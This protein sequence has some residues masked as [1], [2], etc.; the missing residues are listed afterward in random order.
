[1]RSRHEENTTRLLTNRQNEFETDQ[2]CNNILGRNDYYS[3]LIPRIKIINE[4]INIKDFHLFEYI[5]PIDIKSIYVY[6]YIYIYI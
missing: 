6:I 2:I 5:S 3:H 4:T 1:M